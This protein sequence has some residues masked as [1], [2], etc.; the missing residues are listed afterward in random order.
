DLNLLG[1]NDFHGRI[2]SSTPLWAGTIEE[3]RAAGGED[4]TLLWSAGDNIGAS[5][6]ASSVQQDQPTIDVL[7]ALDLDASAVGNH[8]FDQGIADLTDRVIGPDGARN[9]Q[10]AY[11]GAN[12]YTEGTTTPVLDEYALFDLDGV[13]VAVIGAVTQETPSLVLPAGVAG[14]DFGDP[15]E[16]VNRV[17]AQLSDGDE[18]SGEAQVILASLHEG[19]AATSGTLEDAVADSETFASIVNDLSPE[20]DAVINGHTNGKYAFDA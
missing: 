8:E 6:F 12:V 17:A 3:L 15:V 10:W 20:V 9:A 7:N 14:L 2:N 13:S 11:L 18:S 4:T 19:S 16:A 1:F 5:E